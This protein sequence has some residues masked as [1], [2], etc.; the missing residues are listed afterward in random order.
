VDGD[1][2]PD[3][4]PSV[5][6]STVTVGDDRFE[7]GRGG[8]RILVGD[9][10]CDGLATAV[11]V[12]ADPPALWHFPSWAPVDRTVTARLVTDR[13]DPTSVRAQRDE[14]GCSR[15]TAVDV[16]SGDPTPVAVTP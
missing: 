12:R 3:G 5:A 1:G 2:C 4:T 8:D 7:L 13:I 11:V 6:G 16:R 15:L 9:W 14:R 10:D